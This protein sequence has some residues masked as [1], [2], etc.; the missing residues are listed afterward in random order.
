LAPS[1]ISLDHI[2]CR[3]KGVLPSLQLAASAGQRAD[4]LQ[5]IRTVP[6]TVKKTP[7]IT[8]IG[9]VS[10]AGSEFE[11]LTSGYE[12]LSYNLYF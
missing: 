9:G 6:G 7:P 3:T 2:F 10:I 8:M 11:A 5:V 12:L 4:D 1:L